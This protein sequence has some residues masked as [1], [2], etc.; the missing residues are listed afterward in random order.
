MSNPQ[1]VKAEVGG[2]VW[3]IEVAVGQAVAEGDT[4]LIVESMKMEIPLAAP[5][6]GTVLEIRVA[7]TDMVDEDQVVMLIG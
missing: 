2:S 6:A 1:E 4:L 7:E 5:A 3:K